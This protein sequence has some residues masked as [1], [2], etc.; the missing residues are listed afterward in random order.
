MDSA[1]FCGMPVMIDGYEAAKERQRYLIEKMEALDMTLWLARIPSD[2]Q[3]HYPK[4][5]NRVDDDN[6]ETEILDIMREIENLQEIVDIYEDVDDDVDFE[7]DEEALREFEMLCRGRK[8]SLTIPIPD[9]CLSRNPSPCSGAWAPRVAEFEAP[10]NPFR[11]DFYM[12]FEDTITDETEFITVP[13]KAPYSISTIS[14]NS[15]FGDLVDYVREWNPFEVGSSCSSRSS[16]FDSTF[17]FNDMVSDSSVSSDAGDD[18][19]IRKTSQEVSK[20][21]SMEMDMDMTVPLMLDDGNFNNNSNSRRSSV[22]SQCPWGDYLEYDME[23]DDEMDYDDYYE[24]EEMA[25]QTIVHSTPKYADLSSSLLNTTFEDVSFN[26]TIYTEQEVPQSPPFLASE[27]C[28]P[29]VIDPKVIHIELPAYKADYY[30]TFQDAENEAIRTRFLGR[31]HTFFPS[32][33]PSRNTPCTL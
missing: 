2:Q 18:C 29:T 11:E 8:A 5:L 28:T 23:I 33:I 13:G 27:P 7:I 14:H 26:Q 20:T 16:S 17:S 6:M 15:L 32:I 21:E 4:M 10:Y 24:Y 19:S 22:S 9:S 25:H 30:F 12:G 3:F 31:F 1:T